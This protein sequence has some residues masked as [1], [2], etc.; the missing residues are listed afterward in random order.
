[1][2]YVVWQGIAMDYVNN[3]PKVG[4]KAVILTVVDLLSKYAHFIA[5]GHPYTARMVAVAFFEQ[6]IRLH[7]VPTSIV[8][9]RDPIFTSTVWR[10]LFHLC[11]TS[12]AFQPQTYG[13]SEVTNQIIMVY[14]RS[15]VG[16]RPKSWL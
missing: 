1:V 5:L 9:G 12:S 3:F 16:D 14:L 13:Q 10:E 11:G 15:L 7:G 8:S 2:S 6:I 4:G